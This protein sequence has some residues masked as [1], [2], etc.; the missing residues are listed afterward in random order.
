ML[1]CDLLL[2]EAII[3]TNPEL[4]S[5]RD[6]DKMIGFVASHS[7]RAEL[8]QEPVGQSLLVTRYD[9]LKAKNGESFLL[10]DITDLL[11]LPLLG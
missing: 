1:I 2:D 11:G 6:S 4:S 3:C 7:L 10:G 8:G 5:C 9:A